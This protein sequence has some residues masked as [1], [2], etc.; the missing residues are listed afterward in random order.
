VH[1]AV[2][3]ADGVTQFELTAGAGTVTMTVHDASPLPPRPQPLDATRPGGFGWQLVQ[4]VS[5]GVR[6][7]VHASGKTMTAVVPRPTRALPQG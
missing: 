1:H 5:I 2:R 6:V 7:Q 4:D 3:H